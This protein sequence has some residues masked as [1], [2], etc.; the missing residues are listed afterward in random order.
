MNNSYQQFLRSCRSGLPVKIVLSLKGLLPTIYP[1]HLKGEYAQAGHSST[2]LAHL[3]FDQPTG[4]LL[5]HFLRPSIV[6]ARQESYFKND[7]F[8]ASGDHFFSPGVTKSLGWETGKY[9][10]LKGLY[11]ILEDQDFYTVSV[12]VGRFSAVANTPL[13]PR[14]QCLQ[15][16]K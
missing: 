16:A 3:Q 7:V 10:L 13:L 12:R 15:M 9:H 11:P 14:R 4:R 1:I 2:V 6:S 8:R 5:I